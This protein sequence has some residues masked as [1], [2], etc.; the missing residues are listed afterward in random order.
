MCP[1]LLPHDPPPTPSCDMYAVNLPLSVLTPRTCPNQCLNR[2]PARISA[3]TAN[4]PLSY[5]NRKPFRRQKKLTPYR[6]L[7]L[8]L[9]NAHDSPFA[10]RSSLAT[11]GEM[12]EPTWEQPPRQMLAGARL[13]PTRRLECLVLG[14][15]ARTRRRVLLWRRALRLRLPCPTSLWNTPCRPSSRSVRDDG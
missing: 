10:G 5:L 9:T 7:M 2:E 11:A 3:S 1:S 13:A 14:R 8:M 12:T 4:Q 15:R 6:S